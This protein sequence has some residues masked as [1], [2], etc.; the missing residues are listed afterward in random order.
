MHRVHPAC[1][2]GPADE[3]ECSGESHNP[4][5]AN[6]MTQSQPPANSRPVSSAQTSAHA[7]LAALVRRHAGQP[8]RK[9]PAA[10]SS[11]AF[12][13]FLTAWDRRAAPVLD[14]GCGTGESTARLARAAPHRLVVGIDQSAHRL[15]RGPMARDLPANALLLRADIVDFWRLLQGAGVPLHAH[16]I[17]YPNPWPKPTQ[18][19]RRWPAHPVFPSIVALGG[20]LECRSN[21]QVYNDEFA[22]ALTI[23]TGKAHGAE[24]FD[25]AIPLTPFERKYAQSGHTLYRVRADL[26]R[27]A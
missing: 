19:M 14:A 10:Y 24:P 13:R 21:W 23:L 8:F 16:Y 3:T 11:A 25:P 9:P 20:Q 7:A 12:Q 6:A 27:T 2:C 15:A 26:T 18:L 1:D 22:Q 5:Q 17:L 4:R